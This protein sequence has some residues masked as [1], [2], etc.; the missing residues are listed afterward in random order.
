[1][2]CGGP[3]AIIG[4]HQ[5]PKADLRA[6]PVDSQGGAVTPAMHGPGSGPERTHPSIGGPPR[7]ATNKTEDHQHDRLPA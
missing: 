3:R 1:M 2:E 6:T 7:P 4:G 5:G